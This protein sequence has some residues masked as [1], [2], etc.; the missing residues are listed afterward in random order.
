[1]C[2]CG[3]A[4][5]SRHG[6]VTIASRS[7]HGRVTVAPQW[8]PPVSESQDGEGVRGGRGTLGRGNAWGTGNQQGPRRVIAAFSS[9]EEGMRHHESAGS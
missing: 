9:H 7:R 1:M 5:R 6:R 3:Q 4:S 2:A 8:C